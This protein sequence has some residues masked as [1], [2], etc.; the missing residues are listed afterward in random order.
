MEL[1]FSQS[2]KNLMGLAQIVSAILMMS[3]G[4]M[5]SLPAAIE[6]AG[7]AY[8]LKVSGNGHYLVD[9]N[10]VPFFLNGD[11]P[12]A[13][14]YFL[15]A[16][17]KD[18]YLSNRAEKSFNSINMMIASVWDQNP[19]SV[20]GNRL[21]S[22]PTNFATVNDNYLAEIKEVVQKAAARGINCNITTLWLANWRYAY[23]ANSGNVP[24]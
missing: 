16:A 20:G 14:G 15:T 7:P 10:D 17:E 4:F 12:W 23:S 1:L 22:D 18:T 24:I 5:I 6:A 8:P 19:T 3:G 13:I 11:T 21:F 2:K 9:Q